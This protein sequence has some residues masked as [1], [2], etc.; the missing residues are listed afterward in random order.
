MDNKQ[1]E[2]INKIREDFQA[3]QRVKDSLNNSIKALADDLYSKDTHFI[4]ELIQNAEDNE[5]AE[6]V[7]PSISFLLTKD[8]PTNTE[9]SDG[10]LIIQNN[11][12]GFTFEN[13][14]AV[15]AVGKSTKKK[16]QGYIGE[17]GI[18]FK[19]VFRVTSVPHLFSKGYQFCLPEKDAETGLGYIV[20]QWIEHVPND[21]DPCLTTIVLPLD[22]VDFGYDKIQEM[23]CDIKLETILFL[24]KLK[25]V[26]IDA[27]T[28][29]EILKDDSKLPKVEILVNDES[30]NKPDHVDEFLL[31][32]RNFP[33][34]DDI[35]HEKRKGIKE[36]E[37]SIAFLLNKD[38][39]E[40]G[41]IF[42]YLPVRSGTGLPFSINADFILTSSREDIH[43]DLP[44]NKWLMRC[45]AKLLAD[46][47]P[48]LKEQGK[49][50]VALIEAL[51]NRLKDTSDGD[52]F[53]P[54][55]DEVR[56]A[57]LYQELLPADGETFVSAKNAKL[58]RGAELRKLLGDK[59]RQILFSTQSTFKWLSDKITQDKT[60][61]LRTY[62]MNDLGVEEITPDRFARKITSDFLR[63]QSDEWIVAFYQFLNGQPA[64]W[65][66]GDGALRNMPFIRLQDGNHVAPF[67]QDESPNAY[68]P[69]QEDTVFPVVKREI[70]KDEKAMAFLKRLRLTKPDVVAEVIEH[71]IPK[72]SQDYLSIKM[73]IR[74]I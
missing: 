21:I 34:P 41:S 1:R 52:E 62:L 7:E 19:S 17:K 55:A 3:N 35:N 31:Y 60:P 25:E 39:V 63:Q 53:S 45:A 24:S 70:C 46:A 42:A 65:K 18:G 16:A 59:Q 22:K 29:L 28:K 38:K 44:W 48:K 61:V 50:T 20:P 73:N 66:K 37:V 71:I 2:H 10:A 36:R 58:V 8:D 68:L 26:I 9:G 57:L 11:E 4:F 14:D 30:K 13:V 56:N 72:Y 54:I 51:V 74:R 40:E 67:K 15:C 5:Y 49:L 6:R 32:S 64:L 43:W 47:L 69:P 12:V 33:K 23:L 27:G